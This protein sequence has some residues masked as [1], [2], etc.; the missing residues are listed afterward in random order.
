ML[1][2]SL[3][4]VVLATPQSVAVAADAPDVAPARPTKIP[5]TVEY[6]GKADSERGRSFLELLG[7]HFET[8]DSTNVRSLRSAEDAESAFANAD[9]LLIDGN[10]AGKLPRGYAK[11][12]VVVS[13]MGV[14]TA[15]SLGAKLDWL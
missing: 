13:G 7:R 15:E 5:L 8:V 14:K 4:T 11:P 3:L 6:V 9:V 10:L 12:M 2:T 1:A